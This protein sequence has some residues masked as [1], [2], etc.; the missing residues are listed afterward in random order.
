MMQMYLLYH[1]FLFGQC[2]FQLIN[3]ELPG[4]AIKQKWRNGYPR[5]QWPFHSFS[6][7]SSDAYHR[8]TTLVSVLPGEE[9]LAADQPQAGLIIVNQVLK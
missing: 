9:C 7:K 8:K 6:H 3:T 5:S 1:N 4:L 2:K